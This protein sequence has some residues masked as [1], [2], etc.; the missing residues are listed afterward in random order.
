MTYCKQTLK[1]NFPRILVQIMYHPTLLIDHM[2]V[3]Q[4]Y[5]IFYHPTLLIDHMSGIQ[6][7]MIIIYHVFQ[8][9]DLNKEKVQ[10]LKIQWLNYK[11]EQPFN[12]NYKYSNGT[13]YPFYCN[14]IG[15]RNSNV[16]K[17]TENLDLLYPNSHTIS[18][19]EKKDLIELLPF[20]PPPHKTPVLF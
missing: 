4:V 1:W 11:K 9:T 8:K 15:K 10:W 16:Q 20:I 14:Y 7:Q 5:M 18:Q 6:I 12:F 17:Y 3:I 2:P 19:L 13:D